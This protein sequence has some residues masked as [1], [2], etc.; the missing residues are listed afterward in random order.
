MAF[1]VALV[2][3][4]ALALNGFSLLVYFD[5]DRIASFGQEAARYISLAH[6]VLGAVMVGWGMALAV[7]VRTVFAAGYRA[8]WNIVALSVGAWFIPDTGYSLASGY[9]QNAVLNLVF[10]ILF[11]VP[12]V[13]TRKLFRSS[14]G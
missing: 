3:A 2:M 10:L 6:A 14:E 11:A 4:P 9:W 8:S 12:L 5:Q 1:G 7:L 13:A